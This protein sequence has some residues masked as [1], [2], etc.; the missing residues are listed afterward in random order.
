MQS[1][2][3]TFR[4]QW[5][6]DTSINERI[7]AFMDAL[8]TASAG[9]RTLYAFRGRPISSYSRCYRVGPRA[10]RGPTCPASLRAPA[11]QGLGFRV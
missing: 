7:R 2:T 11:I 8:R 5:I 3:D 10:A 6:H 9:P 1:S 4:K